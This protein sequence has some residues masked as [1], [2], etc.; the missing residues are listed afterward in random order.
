M[1]RL[2]Y[3]KIYCV[4]HNVKVYD[5]GQVHEEYEQ[6]LISNFNDAW[7]FR[8]GLP[9]VP[10]VPEVPEP[11]EPSV[12]DTQYS[13][14]YTTNSVA[15]RHPHTIAYPATAGHQGAHHDEEDEDDD[16]RESDDGGEQDDDSDEEEEEEEE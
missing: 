4:E 15:A 12:A 14:P 16:E 2:N 6:L 7:G 9:P 5:F 11:E 8:A 13:Y 10:S 3:L 1:S